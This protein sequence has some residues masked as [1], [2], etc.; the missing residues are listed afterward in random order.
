MAALDGLATGAGFALVL[1]VLGGLREVVGQGTLFSG[2]GLLIG[3]D[4]EQFTLGLPISGLLLALLPPG[5]FLCFGFLLAGVN[6]I[7]GRHGAS[8]SA[9]PDSEPAEAPVP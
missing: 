2:L 1:L 7:N 4:P 8:S 5:A 3:A 6:W 9:A